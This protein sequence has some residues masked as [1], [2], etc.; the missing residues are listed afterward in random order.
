MA[1]FTKLPSGKW[2]VIVKHQGVCVSKSF[3]MKGQAD[4]WARDTMRAI[5]DGTYDDVATTLTLSDA[6]DRYEREFTAKKKGCEQERRRLRQLQAQPFAKKSLQNVA[7]ADLVAFRDQRLQ[8][9]KPQ[10]VYLDLALLSHLFNV[11]K[12]HWLIEIKNPVDDVPK[13][14]VRNSRTR[15]LTDR[16]RE[17][18]WQALASYPNPEFRLIVELAWHTAMRYSEIIHLHVEQLSLKDGIIF[19]EDTKNGEPRMVPLS[20]PAQAALRRFGVKTE[21]PHERIFT[22]TYCG[23]QGS[24]QKFKAELGF[25]DFRFHDLRRECTSALIEAGWSD[26]AVMSIT[27]HKTAQMLK[28]YAHLRTRHLVAK[29]AGDFPDV[30]APGDPEEP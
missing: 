19:L 25:K 26:M 29:L 27:G 24:W 11:A 30:P 22:Y 28:R 1:C 15:R 10:T 13:P 2:R 4:R 7:P 17:K 8:T 14:V 3:S 21:N 9:C 5:E 18:F 20:P 6:L 23:F 12:R 16:E